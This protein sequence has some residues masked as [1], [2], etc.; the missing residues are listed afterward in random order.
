MRTDGTNRVGVVA[1]VATTI[2]C[3]MA[4]TVHTADAVATGVFRASLNAAG[5]DP[6]GA[7]GFNTVAVSGTGRYIVFASDATN[8]VAS[9]TNGQS[10]VFV[11]DTQSNTTERVSVASNG[12]QSNG[13]SVVFSP[14]A[15]SDDGRYVVYLSKATDLAP[16]DS[17]ADAT[18]AGGVDAFLRDRLNGTTTLIARRSDG[19]T[20]DSSV[21]PVISADGSTVALSV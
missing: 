18:N 16:N 6:N 21:N 3:A 8:L 17:N 5:G 14:S 12:S 4:L 10:D 15:I 2:A 13:P 9:D 1:A 19:S 7:S 11:R 20:F